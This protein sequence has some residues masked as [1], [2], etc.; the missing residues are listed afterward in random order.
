MTL[1]QHADELEQEQQQMGMWIN[2]KN[3]M[4]C[5]ECGSNFSLLT[6]KVSTLCLAFHAALSLSLSL[7]L[8][9]ASLQVL[10]KSLLQQV[11]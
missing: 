4:A 10:W 8:S 6:R 1:W 2:S 3:V 7:S 11:L 5:M 9:P